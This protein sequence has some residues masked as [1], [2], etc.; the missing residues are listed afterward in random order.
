MARPNKQGLD[1]FPLDVGVFE[2]EKMLAISG[3]FAVKGEIIV[4][5]LLCEIYRN[6]Y[7]VE[8]SELLK[9]KLARL[10]GLS[11]G[12]IEE[13]VK[14]L[15][16]YGFFDGSLFSEYN[17]LTSKNIQKTYLEATKRRKE[18]DISQFWLLNGVNA[19]INNTSS[20]VN[21]NINLNSLNIWQELKSIHFNFTK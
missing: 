11:G 16:K 3:E 4:L 19:N 20:G 21:V 8:F 18:I 7:F 1:Y 6:G 9:N 17:I 15:V 5:R 12:L 13:V 2:D 14:Q 10:G